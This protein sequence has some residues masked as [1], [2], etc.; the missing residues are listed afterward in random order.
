MSSPTLDLDNQTL[1]K[2]SQLE[3]YNSNGDKV[4]FGSVFKDRKTVVVFIR[5]FFCGQYVMQIA[6]TVRAEAL[7]KANAGIVLVGCGEWELIKEY[8]ADTG[9]EGDVFANPDR[10]LYRA[11]GMVENLKQTP[12]GQPKASYI[13]QS[14]LKT[15]LEATKHTFFHIT[16]FSKSGNI[17]QNGGELVLGPGLNCSYFHRM[18]HTQ[19]HAELVEVMAAA[20]VDY[21]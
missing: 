21:P 15:T 9:F 6:S 17:S 16:Q 14:V 1:E 4:K 12:S 8:K 5:H 19:D 13:T 7:Q 20:G 2:V 10:T 11:L 18:V 3:V